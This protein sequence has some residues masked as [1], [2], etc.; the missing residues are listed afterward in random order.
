MIDYIVNNNNLIELI[1]LIPKMNEFIND[2][3]NRLSLKISEADLDKEIQNINILKDFKF[4]SFNNLLKEIKNK[5]DFK[6]D[7][8]ITQKS[9]ISEIVNI[10]DNKINRLYNE[11]INKY[12]EF[13]KKTKIYEINK[14]RIE[15]VIIQNSSENDYM[16]FKSYDN[17]MILAEERLKEILILCS[18][19]NRIKN[20]KINVYDG[21]K[22][23]YNYELI[24]N[25]L[26]EEFILGKKIFSKTQK[27]FISSLKFWI[28][29]S[30]NLLIE[31]NQKF[32]QEEIEK[33]ITQ[34]ISQKIDNDYN[35]EEKIIEFY[36]NLQYIII[37]LMTYEKN[38][39]YI[40]CKTSITDIIKIVEKENYRINEDFTSFVESFKDC[41]YINS[42][43]A[44]YEMVE[45]K[46]FQY[47]TREIKIDQIE[48]KKETKEKIENELKKDN[49]LLNDK[50]LTNGFKKFIL[51]Y[52]LA[53]NDNNNLIEYMTKYF[54][55]LFNKIDIWGNII[56]NDYRL[57]KERENLI[58]INNDDNCIIKYY[59]NKLI[60]NNEEK[61]DKINPIKEPDDPFNEHNE[62]EDD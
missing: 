34:T 50:I 58:S 30:N 20:E 52:Y 31:L 17:N 4:D 24:E 39:K 23:N 46:A 1:N 11:I 32:K 56:I 62:G 18:S 21:G 60:T 2:I 38:N 3:Y 44:F 40:D 36:Y 5:I 35:S 9:K 47:L 43:L 53:D 25:M 12:N 6:E 48:I 33:D 37:Y 10:K 55:D 54:E 19:R 13:L 49:L 16:I 45:L 7:I 29:D 51:R 41:L 8:N 57:N 22:I 61:N 14:D 15:T 27:T 28:D 42:L 59:C 26:E